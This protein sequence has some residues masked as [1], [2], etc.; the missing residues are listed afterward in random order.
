MIELI[1]IAFPLLALLTFVVVPLYAWLQR[2]RTFAIFSAV[3]MALSLAG[4]WAVHL[5]LPLWL[6][7]TELRLAQAAMTYGMAAAAWHYAHLVRARMRGPLFRW[8]ISVPGQTFIASSFL[9]T[10]W[11]LILLCVR[12]PFWFLD[13]Q[14]AQAVLAPLDGLPYLVGLGAAC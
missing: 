3:V 8:A 11:M 5:R 1:D 13:M 7:G 4:A 14:G 12:A 6:H 2:G 9:A 10:F